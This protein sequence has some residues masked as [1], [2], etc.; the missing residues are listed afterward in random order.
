MLPLCGVIDG[1]V[2]CAHGGIPRATTSLNDI[3]ALPAEISSPQQESAIA[4][5]ILWSDPLAQPLFLEM[6]HI[7]RVD[8]ARCN[9]FLPNKKRGTAW[10]FSEE[11]LNR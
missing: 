3:A 5:E 7:M 2:Y 10:W 11:A 1:A 6:A 9:G 4:W 8:L